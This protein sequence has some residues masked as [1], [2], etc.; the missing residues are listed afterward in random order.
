MPFHNVLHAVVQNYD[1]LAIG[2]R[3]I[4]YDAN[5]CGDRILGS[6]FEPLVLNGTNYFETHIFSDTSHKQ[7]CFMFY[8]EYSRTL[9]DAVFTNADAFY[10]V[11]NSGDFGTT[12]NG[13]GMPIRDGMRTIRIGTQ[14]SS[15]PQFPLPPAPS[16]PISPTDWCSTCTQLDGELRNPFCEAAT[17]CEISTVDAVMRLL[18]GI[19]LDNERNAWDRSVQ[20]RVNACVAMLEEP[21]ELLTSDDIVTF[22]KH[23]I[24]GSA[25]AC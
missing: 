22:A 9:S 2:D 23:R 11:R 17:G 13:L 12:G 4:A 25:A 16:M 7:V 3:L 24:G 6:S 10:F 21:T 18:R 14:V 19:E 1:Q 8:S 15:M 20:S 5:Y